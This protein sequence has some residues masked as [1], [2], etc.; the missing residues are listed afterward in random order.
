VLLDYPSTPE[1]VSP[2]ASLMQLVTSR[3]LV[4][5]DDPD[6]ARQLGRVVARPTAKGWAVASGTGEPIVAA[7][8]AMLAVHRAMTA[9]K[10]PSWKMRYVAG[11]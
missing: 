11:F 3:A 4:H 9:P 10:P 1:R 8:A 5:E 7:Q 2:A 6:L